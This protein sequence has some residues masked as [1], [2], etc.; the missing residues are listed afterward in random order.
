[1]KLKLQAPPGKYIVVRTLNFDGES[2]I[3]A[4]CE[5]LQRAIE[6]I[7][8]SCHIGH[9]SKVY[10]DQGNMLFEDGEVF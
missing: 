7:K 5:T 2:G 3:V 9:H 6:Q 1:M 4:Q 8:R 10:D